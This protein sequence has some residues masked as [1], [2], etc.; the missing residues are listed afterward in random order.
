MDTSTPHATSP[1][2]WRRSLPL[3]AVV[4]S[5]T[6]LFQLVPV[7]LPSWG[8]P[9]AP[10]VSPHLGPWYPCGCVYLI[11]S[12]KCP[13]KSVNSWPPSPLLFH[14]R[15]GGVPWPLRCPHKRIGTCH[16]C[17]RL[18]LVLSFKCPQNSVNLLLPCVCAVTVKG[19]QPLRWS[20]TC[21]HNQDLQLRR[22]TI[23]HCTNHLFT[24]CHLQS[25]WHKKDEIQ[26][27]Q[28]GTSTWHLF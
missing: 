11:P 26:P 8:C 12:P 19:R 18:C 21:P 22:H 23:T 3:S 24:T 20:Q 25:R 16:P 1:Q 14:R 6:S 27:H 2:S 10:Q 13:H 17:G 5:A 15:F 4:L 7:S 28:R 9:M